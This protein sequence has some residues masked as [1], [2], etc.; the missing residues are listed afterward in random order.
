ME[1]E[2]SCWRENVVEAYWDE[3]YE[4][5]KKETILR[6]RLMEYTKLYN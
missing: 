3:G 1:V 5:G 4:E 2:Q 6:F